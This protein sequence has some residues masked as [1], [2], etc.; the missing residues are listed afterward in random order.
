MIINKE[1]DPHT[2]IIETFA[3]EDNRLIEHFSSDIT[4][5]IERNKDKQK[6]SN[7]ILSND[8]NTNLRE[9]AELDHVTYLR[10]ISEHNID[11]FNP[12]D[13]SKFKKWLNKPENKYFKTVNGRV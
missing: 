12:Y 6:Y 8:S 7:S 10:L 5:L 13:L 4:K 11:V 9:I 3:S 1:Y 2:G